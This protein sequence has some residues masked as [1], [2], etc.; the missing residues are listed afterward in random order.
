MDGSYL[1][2]RIYLYPE[3]T[4]RQRLRTL[5]VIA[6]LYTYDGCNSDVTFLT[7]SQLNHFESETNS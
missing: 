5:P 6:V 2:W 4:K 1:G 3:G 7:P